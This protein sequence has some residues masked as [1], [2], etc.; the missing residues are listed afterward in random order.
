MKTRTPLFA[1]ALTLAALAAPT[2]SRELSAAENPLDE[3]ISIQLKNALPAEVFE[4]FGQLTGMPTVVD[5]TVSRHLSIGLENVR[6]KTALDATCE[7]LDCRWEV[8]NGKLVIT[9][10]PGGDRKPPAKTEP[11]E[12][13][14]IKVVNA[15]LQNLLKTF[16]QLVGAEVVLDPALTGKISVDLPNTPWD[17]GLDTVCKQAGCTWSL[18]DG[19]KGG[20]KVLRVT[21]KG[22]RKGA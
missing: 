8:Q 19:E 5:P 9:A 16:G 3:R 20:K 22:G 18:T 1:V 7:S 14:S 13:I 11:T 12:A 2:L 6:V 15:D 21:T 10:L 17:K 4:S